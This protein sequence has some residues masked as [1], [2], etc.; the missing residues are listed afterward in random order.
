MKHMQKATIVKTWIWGLVAML[1][2]TFSSLSVPILSNPG[3]ALHGQTTT[4]VIILIVCGMVALGGIVVQTIA[5]LGAVFNTRRATEKSWF[6]VLLYGGVAGILTMPFFGF[7]ALIAWAAT[8]P[9]L[10]AGPD[11]ISA[12][13]TRLTKGATSP[14]VAQDS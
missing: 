3:N 8:I 13:L 9:Y 2:A 11:G 14:N 1:L 10:I 5:W 12:E 4:A 7:G 6:Y